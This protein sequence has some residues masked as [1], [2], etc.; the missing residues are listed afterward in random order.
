MEVVGIEVPK[1]RSSTI[2]YRSYLTFYSALQ[3]DRL[4]FLTLNVC[5]GCRTPVGLLKRWQCHVRLP[6]CPPTVYFVWNVLPFVSAYPE[7]ASPPPGSRQCVCLLESFLE[8]SA[9]CGKVAGW[10]QKARV[11]R[12]GHHGSFISRL[13]HWRVA[14]LR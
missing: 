4:F 6:P 11:L 2:V 9:A 8:S 7:A 13:C 5:L 14:G 12:P 3:A 1:A 10:W